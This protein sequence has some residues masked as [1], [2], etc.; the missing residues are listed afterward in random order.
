MELDDGSGDQGQPDDTEQEWPRGM[1]ESARFVGS[2]MR[3][4][5]RGVSIV[6]LVVQSTYHMQNLC[7]R[8][9]WIEQLEGIRA[10]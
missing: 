2:G 7:P 5:R 1:P 6:E 3:P 8:G 4:I 10:T 9:P